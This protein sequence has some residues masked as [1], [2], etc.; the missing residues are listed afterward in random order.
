MQ[1]GSLPNSAQPPAAV[2]SSSDRKL[3]ETLAECIA[4]SDPPNAKTSGN[5]V[6]ALMD[7]ATN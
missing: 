3:C 4:S 5:I 6:E 2:D 1:S 7:R